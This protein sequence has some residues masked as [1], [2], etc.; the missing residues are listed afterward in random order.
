MT[1]IHTTPLFSCCPPSPYDAEL[2]SAGPSGHLMETIIIL[3]LQIYLKFKTTT[4]WNLNYHENYHENLII[5]RHGC[6]CRQ[7]HIH[8]I[9]PPFQTITLL[10]APNVTSLKKC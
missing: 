2:M 3:L 7:I 5:I 1:K 9:C 10:S 4:L 8:H 6:T